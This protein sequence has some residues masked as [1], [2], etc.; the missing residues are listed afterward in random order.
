MSLGIKNT[1]FCLKG[2]KHCY[3]FVQGK[4]SL[5]RDMFSFLFKQFG[6]RESSQYVFRAEYGQLRVGLYITVTKSLLVTNHYQ[7]D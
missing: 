6:S 5:V 2:T 1:I 3:K 4:P 7:E